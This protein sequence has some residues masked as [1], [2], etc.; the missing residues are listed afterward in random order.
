MEKPQQNDQ[1]KIKQPYIESVCNSMC[2]RN[3]QSW[4][5][6]V[7]TGVVWLLH[8]NCSDLVSQPDS[9]EPLRSL[10]LVLIHTA[11]L[12]QS[13]PPEKCEDLGGAG[14]R[15]EGVSRRPGS[16]LLSVRKQ[17]LKGSSGRTDS[18]VMAK[19]FQQ[20]RHVQEPSVL[21]L[22]VRTL[23]VCLVWRTA[24]GEK[25]TIEVNHVS[26]R[27]RKSFLPRGTPPSTL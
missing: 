19:T 17:F 24:N 6:F 25:S 1:E 15:E 22:R 16:V 3:D 9:S 21:S 27:S 23:F 5:L 26:K 11:A 18:A 12:Y 13:T 14:R 2:L 7:G 4:G 8:G 10:H 20:S